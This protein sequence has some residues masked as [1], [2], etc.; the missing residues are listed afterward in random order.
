MQHTTSPVDPPTGTQSRPVLQH[1][2]NILHSASKLATPKTR[3]H[4]AGWSPIIDKEPVQPIES[5][6]KVDDR[7]PVQR[8]APNAVQVTPSHQD[9]VEKSIPPTRQVA[10]KSSPRHS[11]KTP[12]GHPSHTL[13]PE[14]PTPPSISR[15]GTATGIYSENDSKSQQHPG[16][17]P[18]G[19]VQ[20]PTPSQYPTRKANP[21]DSERIYPSRTW[22]HRPA[23]VES[24]DVIGAS[25]SRPGTS[26]GF[27]PDATVKSQPFSNVSQEARP[28]IGS[29]PPTPTIG[30]RRLDNEKL[31]KTYQS[32]D[33]RSQPQQVQADAALE[34]PNSS[35]PNTSERRQRDAG[36][37]LSSTLFHMMS[38]QPSVDPRK[39]EN[40]PMLSRSNRILEGK[41]QEGTNVT[42][43]G[44]GA[45][46]TSGVRN[47]MAVVTSRGASSSF[48]HQDSSKVQEP[49]LPLQWVESN[50]NARNATTS[51]DRT[52]MQPN[53]N[54][55][56]NSPL[57]KAHSGST[58]PLLVQHTFPSGTEDISRPSTGTH[59][60]DTV[61]PRVES[62]RTAPAP[63]LLSP[64]MTSVSV[65]R[66]NDTT[67]FRLDGRPPAQ[68]YVLPPQYT[69]DAHR[70]FS[71]MQEEQR[72]KGAAIAPT[73]DSV[74]PFP[75]QEVYTFPVARQYESQRV[76]AD[77]KPTAPDQPAN[78]APFEAAEQPRS[79]RRDDHDIRRID[80]QPSDQ[81]L[82]DTEPHK[83]YDRNGPRVRSDSQPIAS[84]TKILS[85]QLTEGASQGSSNVVIN[86]EVPRSEIDRPV[87]DSKQ[88]SVVLVVPKEIVTVPSRS[89][90]P[91]ITS[92]PHGGNTVQKTSSS[93]PANENL[94]GA[95]APLHIEG[96]T[97]CSHDLMNP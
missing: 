3:D 14:N 76:R 20:V 63:E 30:L 50:S 91:D 84:T 33:S 46:G 32:F 88:A 79:S 69:K 42:T 15:S 13:E 37:G 65:R 92:G 43:A 17:L 96:E 73:N 39:T 89:R 62:L 36:T 49:M 54:S 9:V 77:S 16:Y 24:Q 48:P 58:A 87:P 95:S 8:L 29:V 6:A 1:V 31:D 19:N 94:P 78:D 10:F 40:E 7:L 28:K 34:V 67:R 45:P 4:T 22:S 68:D 74:R 27:R 72:I 26:S 25:L 86:Q 71:H 53:S 2:E 90:N 12:I 52:G 97:L 11:P 64:R 51:R 44:L 41:E 59:T 85:T 21:D 47:D 61:R 83:Y 55:N 57:V 38:Q 35:R 93:Q 5:N 18:G 66:E 75:M 23:F 60:Q 56:E 70:P 80:N 81:I 82:R